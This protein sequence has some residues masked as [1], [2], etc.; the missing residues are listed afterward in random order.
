MV[1]GGQIVIACS[2]NSIANASATLTDSTYKLTVKSTT[3]PRVDV[4]FANTDASNEYIYTC[5]KGQAI[6]SVSEQ[7]GR[8]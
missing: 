5:I 3:D 6:R 4:V 7:P 8:R 2:G 1:P